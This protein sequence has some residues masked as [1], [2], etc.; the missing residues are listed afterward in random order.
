MKDEPL[1]CLS[2]EEQLLGLSLTVSQYRFDELHN[3]F[4]SVATCHAMCSQ[5][6]LWM[7]AML[8]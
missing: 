7:R 6:I 3:V 8:S 5:P 2:E 1:V 4:A